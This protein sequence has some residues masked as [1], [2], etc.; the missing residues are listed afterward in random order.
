MHKTSADNRKVRNEELR[1]EKD[2]I[3]GLKDE[4]KDQYIKG[5]Y[6]ARQAILERVKERKR[7]KEEV[8]KRGSIK[9]K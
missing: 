6:D 9:N 1:K 8:S 4:D 7:I 5:L 3:E 2:R